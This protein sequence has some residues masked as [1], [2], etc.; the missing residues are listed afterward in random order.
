MPVK[1]VT[2]DKS[3][4]D[5]YSK[6]YYLVSL[7]PVFHGLSLENY[8]GVCADACGG[9]GLDKIHSLEI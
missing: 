4:H 3:I 2:F 7:N 8:G 5:A 6:S 1:I 9:F